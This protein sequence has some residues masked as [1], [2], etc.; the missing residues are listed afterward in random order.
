MNTITIRKIDGSTTG[1]NRWR[2]AIVLRYDAPAWA[3]AWGLGHAL[4]VFPAVEYNARLQGAPSGALGNHHTL[5]LMRDLIN[6]GKVDPLV[7]RA[8]HSIIYTQPERDEIGE[9]AALF[10]YVRDHVR[11]VRDV[12]GVETLCAPAMTLQRLIGDCDDQTMLLC[13]LAEAAGYPTRLVMAGYSSAAFE[14]VYCEIFALGAW[15]A[16]DATERAAHFGWA[17]P[18]PVRMFTESV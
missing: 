18:D 14:H 1:P 10:D 5:R 4:R 9:C 17:P 7:M 16:C 12:H 11:Y 8:A 2:P 13:A 6:A 3:V 15:Y